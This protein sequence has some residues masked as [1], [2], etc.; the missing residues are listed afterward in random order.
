MKLTQTAQL[1]LYY[2]MLRLRRVEEA[3]ADAYPKQKMRT[4]V[5][6]SIGQEAAAATA[7]FVLK[8]S[9]YAVST[10]RGHAHYLAKGGSLKAMIAEI[11]GKVTGCC[12]GRGGSMH[13]I[14]QSVGFMGSTAIVGNTIPIGVG[15]GLAASLEGSSRIS[16]IFLGDGA[17]EE[18]VFYE[19]LNFAVVR[20]LPVLF[21]CENNLYSVYSPFHKRQPMA[22]KIYEMVRGMGAETLHVDG[23]DVFAS[24]KAAEQA[25]SHVRAGLGPFFLEL[26]TYRWREHCGPY[27]DNDIGYRTVEEYESWLARDP[28]ARFRQSLM[29]EFSLDPSVFDAMEAR[30]REE[31]QE[32]FEAA[33]AA[34]F[35]DSIE[36]IQGEYQE[37]PVKQ[38]V[39]VCAG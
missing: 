23:Y 13:L 31:I 5:H 10:H 18:G 14:D 19:S 24:I 2:T 30:I 20:Q 16:C 12:R 35:P 9:D 32:A 3:I 29:E 28:I 6:L 38:E 7:G 39:H 4:P 25:V 36:A 37:S 8:S 21:F 26:S 17:V 33:E 1:E 22:R 27:Y 15:L 11:H 34:P